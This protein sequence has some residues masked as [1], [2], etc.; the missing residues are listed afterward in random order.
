MVCA[1][2]EASTLPRPTRNGV[3]EIRV[4]NS[5]LMVTGLGPG[6]GKKNPY[7]VEGDVGGKRI[8]ELA[9]LRTNEV[10]IKEL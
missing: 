1:K 9:R 2:I 10:A 6:V 8:E 4:E 3:E 5:V 7:F